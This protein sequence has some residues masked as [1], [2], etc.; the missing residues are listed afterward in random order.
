M[1][2]GTLSDCLE[3]SAMA[4]GAAPAL[5]FPDL[6]ISYAQFYDRVRR[7]AEALAPAAL[8]SGAITVSISE[9]LTVLECVFASGLIRRPAMLIDP[10]LPM[11]TILSL[12][13]DYPPA[14]LIA[15]ERL[16]NAVDETD[17]DG[18]R[19]LTRDDGCERPLVDPAE[20]EFFW[21]LTS[22]TTG[23]PKVF[24]R[25]HASWIA[26]FEAA[27]GAFA[28][29]DDSSV[30]IPGSLYHS[31]FLY[32]A[33]HALCR[34]HTVLMDNGESFRPSRVAALAAN[35]THLY[36]VPVM[37]DQY[38]RAGLPMGRLQLAFCGGSKLTTEAREKAEAAWPRADIVEFYGASETSFISYSSTSYPAKPA[39]VGRAF[40]TVAL[41]IRGADGRVLPEGE[42]GEIFV[43]SPMLMR[44]YVG[45]DP[46]GRWFSA[47]DMGFLDRDGHLHLT[48]RTN[49]MFKSKGLKIHPEAIET[50]LLKMP[51][52]R[53]AAVVS[54]PDPLRGAIAAAAIEIS[55]G[56]SLSRNRLS[57]HC[58][59]LLGPQLSPSLYF[60]TDRLPT[61]TSG[62]IAVAEIRK[63]LVERWPSFRELK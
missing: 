53:R 38:R 22:G 36:A 63:A 50:A 19:K 61:T 48:G 44:R 37:I 11:E 18:S 56:A 45:D 4:R 8:R 5:I 26:S 10:R 40:P 46:I 15:D 13:R 2:K 58:R 23:R 57:I 14:I 43:S 7:R 30:L 49:R 3:K 55:D 33:V 60:E 29:H 16:R 17:T 34:G 54:L 28:F 31:L 35:A 59:A 20:E 52:V 41:R 27:E 51:G 6:T 42:E 39:S 9:P 21:G 12:C 47:G 1:S 25:A 32:G 24:A 62:K